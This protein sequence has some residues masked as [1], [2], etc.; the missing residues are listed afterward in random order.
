MKFTAR[1]QMSQSLFRTSG[2]S[3][4]SRLN[5]EDKLNLSP[6]PTDAASELDILGHDG[7]ALGVDGTQVGVLEEPNQVSFARFCS[8]HNGR[9]LKPQL[10]HEI[11][12][13]V[14]NQIAGS[15]NNGLRSSVLF[16]VTA[17]LSEGHVPT[18]AMRFLDASSCGCRFAGGLGRQ[19]LS[20]CFASCTL[21]SSLFCTSHGC[22]DLKYA[23]YITR[24][25]MNVRRK[26]RSLYI[27]SARIL[28][29]IRS[30]SAVTSRW[31]STCRYQFSS[32]YPPPIIL[33]V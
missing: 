26:E 13:Y 32:V 17:N 3:E 29:T 4:K 25:R 31:R 5:V 8:C 11:S 20:R 12:R 16:M 14:T 15:D 21:T 30:Y 9:I 18:I 19:L 10:S 2:G 23:A 33:F 7:H 1:K 24:Q 27:D 22:L 28:R 6:F